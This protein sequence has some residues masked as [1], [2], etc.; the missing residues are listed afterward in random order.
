MS[1]F[2][3]QIHSFSYF[4]RPLLLCYLVTLFRSQSLHPLAT[5]HAGHADDDEGN[6]KQLA[7]VEQHTCLEVH[8]IG[9]RVLDEVAEREDERQH[10]SEEES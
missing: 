10:Q 9:L 5:Y 6:R 3:H 2:A 8:L 1:E 4:K 7:H